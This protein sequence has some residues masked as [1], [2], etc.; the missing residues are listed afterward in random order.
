MG[1]YV[2]VEFTAPKRVLESIPESVALLLVAGADS[3]NGVGVNWPGTSVP[4]TKEGLEVWL[5]PRILVELLPTTTVM[6]MKPDWVDVTSVGPGAWVA[7]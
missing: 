1:V 3:E 7:V 4:V 2:G 6:V 5:P